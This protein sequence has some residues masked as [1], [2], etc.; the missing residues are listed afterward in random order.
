MHY[1]TLHQQQHPRQHGGLQSSKTVA[2]FWK[3]WRLKMSSQSD[4]RSFVAMQIYI[5]FK[6]VI[7]INVYRRKATLVKDKYV[8]A[9]MQDN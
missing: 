3:K 1:I 8:H 9:V 2:D 6:K 4:R 7:F 5:K